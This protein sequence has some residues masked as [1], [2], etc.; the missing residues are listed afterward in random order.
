MKI[1]PE[2]LIMCIYVLIPIISIIVPLLIFY[3][4]A[5]PNDRSIVRYEVVLY[6]VKGKNQYNLEKHFQINF[7]FFKVWKLHKT[8]ASSNDVGDLIKYMKS[9]GFIK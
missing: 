5:K 7:L 1:D 8:L 9:H 4:I 6:E 2:Y 3:S